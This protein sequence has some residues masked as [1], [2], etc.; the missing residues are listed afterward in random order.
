[1]LANL[2]FDK[3]QTVLEE[4]VNGGLLQPD[5]NQPRFLRL[6]PIF[7]YF[8]RTRLNK[9]EQAET[10]KAIKTS[11]LKLYMQLSI[12]FYGLL[13]SE[14]SRE[15][16]LGVLFVQYEYENIFSAVK[17]VSEDPNLHNL[18]YAILSEYFDL[19]QDPQKGL[20]VA[21]DVWNRLISAKINQSYSQTQEEMAAV[22]LGDFARWHLRLRH[23]SKAEKYYQEALQISIKQNDRASQAVNYT[24]LG[25]VALEQE[26]F[27]Q[28][29]AYFQQAL[30]IFI[31]NKDHS[32]QAGVY[33]KLGIIAQRQGEFEKA[34]AY[35]HKDLLINTEDKNPYEQAISY[36]Q[37][38]S[39]YQEQGEFEQAE[40]YL[41][42]ALPIFIEYN[43]L[44]F[45][46][47]AYHNLGIVAL[48]QGRFEQAE[49]YLQQDLLICIES[50]DRYS[51]ASTY[52]QLA[53]I[54]MMQG[55]FEQAEAYLRQALL[56][57]IEFNERSEQI[58]TYYNLGSAALEQDKFEQAQ[59][60]FYK[61]LEM[62]AENKDSERFLD[63]LS[64]LAQVWKVTREQSLLPN[65]ASVLKGTQE[66]VEA[67]FRRILET[68]PS[69]PKEEP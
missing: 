38:G 19:T 50:E 48:K 57:Y 45:Q 49:K 39:V 36:H 21:K 22:L 62:V 34:E 41:L 12:E 13:K 55:K 44:R 2:P 10:Y 52:D 14:D 16:N 40:K 51:Q 5:Q 33:Q 61:A 69:D 43:N 30:Q 27:E 17:L 4:A 15:I 29:E 7:P 9:S 60:A 37:L 59:A 66:E 11:F 47:N 54:D 32:S 1:M 67:L 56:I 8:L 20:E 46:A 31:F 65:I 6:Q 28:A 53:T 58:R 24:Q 35:Y 26:K 23:F 25:M 63:I 64:G 68:R 3:W 18:P 42:L